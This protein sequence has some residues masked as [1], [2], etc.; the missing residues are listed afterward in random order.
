MNLGTR[1]LNSVDYAG[2]GVFAGFGLRL[3]WA[4]ASVLLSAASVHAQA[5]SLES[6]IEEAPEALPLGQDSKLVL[7]LTWPNRGEDLL[8]V[9]LP[10][11]TANIRILDGDITSKIRA[12]TSIITITYVVSGIEVGPAEIGPFAAVLVDSTGATADSISVPAVAME[13]REPSQNRVVLILIPVA[14]S[15]AVLSAA[16][17]LRRRSPKVLRDEPQESDI[18]AKLDELSARTESEGFLEE[19]ESIAREFLSGLLTIDASKL[20]PREVAEELS[21]KGFD[22][23]QMVVA[24]SFFSKVQDMR[25]SDA[26][27]SPEEL[28]GVLF[29]LRNLVRA[30]EK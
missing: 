21:R 16:I 23:E 19:C 12:D 26:P 8:P 24:E 10:F 28:G 14:L 2:P 6:I 5:G 7:S 13:I 3:L 18:P 20:T 1:N 17:V 15:V 30:F 11:E 27:T 25:F 22:K 29:D 4:A 9:L